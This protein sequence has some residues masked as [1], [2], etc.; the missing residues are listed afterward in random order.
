MRGSPPR[1]L[2]TCRTKLR[3]KPDR[4]ECRP[5]TRVAVAETAVERAGAVAPGAAAAAEGWEGSLEAD[6]QATAAA[7]WV[8]Y[9]EAAAQATA[10]A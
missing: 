7:R 9:A 8:G 4:C 6:A 2:R 1:P 10:A 3:S 5:H